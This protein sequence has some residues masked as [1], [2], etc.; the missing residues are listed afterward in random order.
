[1]RTREETKLC[2]LKL[3][4]PYSCFCHKHWHYKLYMLVLLLTGHNA[5]RAE[6]ESESMVN[7]WMDDGVI[8]ALTV[9]G[10]SENIYNII[11]QYTLFIDDRLADNWVFLLAYWCKQSYLASIKRTSDMS[12]LIKWSVVHILISRF[13]MGFKIILKSYCYSFILTTNNWHP[14]WIHTNIFQIIL[15]NKNFVIEIFI[16]YVYMFERIYRNILYSH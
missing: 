8:G 5:K 16:V 10:H 7:E 4:Y 12:L 6:Q 11:A 1:M 13:T 9:F 3:S 15:I 14:V 2:C